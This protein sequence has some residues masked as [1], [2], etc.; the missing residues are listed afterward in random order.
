MSYTFNPNKQEIK[1]NVEDTM[2]GIKLLY[3]KD[4]YSKMALLKAAYSFVDMAYIHLNSDDKNYIVELTQKE[5]SDIDIKRE[6]DNE[7]LTQA[8]RD[9]VYKS[10]KNIR[11]LLVARSLASTV[12]D[13]SDSIQDN[14]EENFEE[15]TIIN[16]WFDKN[17]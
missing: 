10:T 1:A 13:N 2:D 5:E 14:P 12:I 15:N 16:D 9:T 3:S 4:L 17:D 8:I 6:F 7:M 11:E